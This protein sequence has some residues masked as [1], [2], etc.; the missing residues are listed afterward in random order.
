[1]DYDYDA[2]HT[3]DGDLVDIGGGQLLQ[4]RERTAGPASLFI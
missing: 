3:S 4:R 2:G 1:M